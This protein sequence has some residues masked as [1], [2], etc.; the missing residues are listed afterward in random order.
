MGEDAGELIGRGLADRGGKKR[1]GF[2]GRVFR[3]GQ[4]ED[5]E[6]GAGRLA[7]PA[8]QK[9]RDCGGGRGPACDGGFV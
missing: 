4:I 9:R 5:G 7:E 8:L 1:A 2:K 6:L 3:V